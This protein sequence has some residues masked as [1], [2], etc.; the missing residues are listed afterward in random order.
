MLA[1]RLV[2]ARPR[3]RNIRTARVAALQRRAKTA[4]KRCANLRPFFAGLATVLVLLMGYVMLIS[5]LTGL[6]YAVARAERERVA[7]QD[8]TARLDD[9]IATLRSQERL[10]SIATEFGMRDPQEFAI[11]TVPRELK[12]AAPRPRLALLS[13][14]GWL[15]TTR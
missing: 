1:S 8:Q 14:F 13:T 4:Q 5:N 10:A 2:E 15:G 11:V 12:R 3:V 7:L 6:N 9:R